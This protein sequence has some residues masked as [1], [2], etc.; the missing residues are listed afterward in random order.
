[1]K[2]NM[3][4]CELGDALFRLHPTPRQDEMPRT[5]KEMPGPTRPTFKEMWDYLMIKFGEVPRQG[6]VIR[7]GGRDRGEDRG[8]L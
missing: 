4:L 5:L 2:C 1:M 7:H 8:L 3:L 6:A